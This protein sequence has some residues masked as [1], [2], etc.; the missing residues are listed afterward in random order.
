MSKKFELGHLV[1]TSGPLQVMHLSPRVL[2]QGMQFAL[3][4]YSPSLHYL[5]P[6]PYTVDTDITIVNRA[7]SMIANRISLT[8]DFDLHSINPAIDEV[9]CLRI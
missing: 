1:Q 8:C 2:L 3:S 5:I 6:N 7:P 9:F 4:L